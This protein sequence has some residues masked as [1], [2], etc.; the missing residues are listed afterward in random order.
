MSKLM[1]VKPSVK[2]L[3]RGLAVCKNTVIEK[4]PIILTTIGVG[5]VVTTGVMAYRAGLKAERVLEEVRHEKGDE[6]LTIEETVK[7]TWKLWVPPVASGVLTVGAIVA[8]AAISEKR[9]AALA[10]LYAVAE[11]SLKQYQDKVEE[12]FGATEERKIREEIHKDLV[13]DEEIPPYG[14]GDGQTWWKDRLTGR[15]IRAN[16]SQINSAASD[17]AQQ[18]LEG[19]MCAS[20]NEFWDILSEKTGHSIDRTRL[21]DEVGWNLHNL[22]RPYLTCQLTSAGEPIGVID[23]DDRRGAPE[24]DY[25]DI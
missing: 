13:R 11:A 6:N 3:T 9:R 4:S 25:R 17:L 10:G 8:S 16:A 7:A 20:L 15:L 5:G 24:A 12:K 1:L 2:T 23:W 14:P 19:D 21:G 18:I 22:P